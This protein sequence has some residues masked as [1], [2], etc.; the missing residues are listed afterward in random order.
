MVKA[1]LSDPGPVN[2]LSVAQ[3][4]VILRLDRAGVIREARVANDIGGESV[5]GW[6]GHPWISTVPRAGGENI[7]HLMQDGLAS[8][9]S[10]FH[11]VTQRFPSG[12]EIPIEYNTVRLGD[13]SG[14]IAVGK[15]LRAVAEVTSRIVA[16][17]AAREQD[18]WK[19]REIET[20][21][22]LLF[23]AAQDPV[24][25]LNLDTLRVEEANPA[26]LRNCGAVVGWPLHLLIAADDLGPTEA[27]MEVAR[28]QGR[29]PAIRVRVGPDRTPWMVRALRS[30]S[31]SG[32]VML[33]QLT[34]P[35]PRPPAGETTPPLDVPGLEKLAERFPIAFVLTDPHG[36]IL[37]ANRA[38]LDLA[39][40]VVPSSV[41]GAPIARWLAEPG[42]DSEVLLLALR[43]HGAVRTFH[44]RLVGSLGTSNA[45]EITAVGDGDENATVLGMLVRDLRD[46]RFTSPRERITDV[47]S[48]MG[49]QIGRTPLLQLVREASDTIE[50]YYIDA[51]LQHA[52]GNRTA[53]AELLGLSRQSLY[54]KLNKYGLG[55]VADEAD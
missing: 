1:Q 51:A 34:S 46:R 18:H 28:V 22:R 32:A 25:L 7:Q 27:M 12:L 9:V 45:V 53:T 44:T 47:L 8:G 37:S 33:L 54:A 39:Q 3:P 55:S 41:I 36:T 19:L 21:Y 6:V 50:R 5:E 31:A 14:L 2:N 10:P 13:E 24:I 4:D 17:Q 11:K 23:D 42:L 26:A 49:D 52:A 35:A 38:F 40:E 43:R 48:D 29:A 20:R 16:A 30:A 15:C